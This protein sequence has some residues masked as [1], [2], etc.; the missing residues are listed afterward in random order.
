MKYLFD[1]KYDNR[2]LETISVE[3]D[4]Y[5]EALAGAVE[6]ANDSIQAEPICAECKV[7]FLEGDQKEVG[8]CT[9]CQ[10]KLNQA[11]NPDLTKEELL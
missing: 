4:S 3:A 10:E 7:E 9:E 5:K 2:W 11:K 6:I 1:M 8:V